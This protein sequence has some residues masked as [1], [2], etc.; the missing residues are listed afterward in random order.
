MLTPLTCQNMSDDAGTD[1]REAIVKAARDLLVSGGIDALSMRKVAA[2]VGV[3]ATAIYR[4][5]ENKEALLSAAVVRGARI[6]GSYLQDGLNETIPLGRLLRMSQCYFDFAREHRYDYQVLFMLDCEQIGMHKLDQRAQAE[7]NATFQM[8]I[9]RIVDC[10]NSGD[11]LPGDPA[12]LAIFVWS[13]FHGLASLRIAGRMDVDE[14]AFAAL[15]EQQIERTV[16]VISTPAGVTCRNHLFSSAKRARA[17]C[18]PR[19]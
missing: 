14:L 5:F 10:Q 19:Q 9:D 4:H 17:L 15:V 18:H 12:N 11:V 8:L 13:A 7:T 3:S 2:A 6:F 1:T 16:D